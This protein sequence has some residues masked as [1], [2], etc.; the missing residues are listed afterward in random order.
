[1]CSVSAVEGVSAPCPA[2]QGGWGGTFPEREPGLARAP[3]AHVTPTPHPSL[4]QGT[5]KAKLSSGR[6]YVYRADPWR[7]TARYRP[8]VAEKPKR[9]GDPMAEEGQTMPVT[10]ISP[11]LHPRVAESGREWTVGV[12]R[13]P[14][15]G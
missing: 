1:M 11:F 5:A 4:L 2:V 15:S 9:R 8:G 7:E 13:W 10:L 14:F 6:D 12:G 3:G